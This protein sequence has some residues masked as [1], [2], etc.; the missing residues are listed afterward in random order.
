VLRSRSS[1]ILDETKL[2][3]YATLVAKAPTLTRIC[4][5]YLDPDPAILTNAVPDPIPISDLNPGLKLSNADPDP[6]HST[7]GSKMNKFS[8]KKSLRVS[9]GT[10]TTVHVLFSVYTKTSNFNILKH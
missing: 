2:Y 7:L 5:H 8:R 3:H 10:G 1:A 6:K 9:S 4:I